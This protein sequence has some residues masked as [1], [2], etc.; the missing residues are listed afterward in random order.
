MLVLLNR[1]SNNKTIIKPIAIQTAIRMSTS[2]I[3]SPVHSSKRSRSASNTDTAI[4]TADSTPSYSL[5]SYYRS[6]CSW[7]VRMCLLYK[8]IPY[9]LKPI[10]LLK[11]EQSSNEYS[12][13]N[14][15]QSVPTLQI[16]NSNRYIS[17][18]LAILNYLNLVHSSNE[19][20]NIY[21]TDPYLLAKCIQLCEIINSDTQP[22]T[23]LKILNAVE[24]LKPSNNNSNTKLEWAQKYMLAGLKSYEIVCTGISGDYS[25]GN[26]ITAADFCLIPQ[27]YNARRNKLILTESEFPNLLRI[28][29][30]L[31]K[32]EWFKAAHPDSQPDNDTITP[33]A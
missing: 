22:I 11:S 4:N 3:K 17:Q 30:N 31:S 7:R 16:D 33:T 5:Y 15:A 18:S 26:T 21:P 1:L 32:Q 28:E 2:P 20:N 19:S 10:H 6:S 8:S 25:I 14:P 13:I 27:L 24:L 29:S 23:N 9:Q 12:A